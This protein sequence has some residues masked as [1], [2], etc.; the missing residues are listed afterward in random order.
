MSS[1]PL[2][3][4]RKERTRL[5]LHHGLRAAGFCLAFGAVAALIAGLL[6]GAFQS[7]NERAVMIIF[8]ICTSPAWFLALY[9]LYK[10]IDEEIAEISR[11]KDLQNLYRI[12]AMSAPGAFLAKAK[13]ESILTSRQTFLTPELIMQSG[14]IGSSILLQTVTSL[15]IEAFPGAKPYLL[16]HVK[17]GEEHCTYKVECS[18]PMRLERSGL[19]PIP[20]QAA[21][22]CSWFQSHAPQCRITVSAS[23]LTQNTFPQDRMHL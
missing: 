7:K 16:L 21:R 9:G 1:D 11:A 17:A 14:E 13:A 15:D 4:A 8:M 3:E 22:I 6:L 5:L 2:H 23:S 10:K 19:L 20:E 12:D 18:N